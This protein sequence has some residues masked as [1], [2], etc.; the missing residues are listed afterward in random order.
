M[1]V[2]RWQVARR[3]EGRVSVVLFGHIHGGKAAS[4]DLESRSQFNLR[5]PIRQVMV[6]YKGIYSLDH[7]QIPLSVMPGGTMRDVK[8]GQTLR[9]S[10]S[11]NMTRCCASIPAMSWFREQF[12]AYDDCIVG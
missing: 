6:V 5:V 4:R 1:P 11:G 2:V 10:P 8:T 9:R 7:I 3:K 12:L